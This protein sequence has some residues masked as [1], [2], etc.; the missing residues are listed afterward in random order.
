MR[1]LWVINRVLPLFYKELGR[2]ESN[3]GGGWLTGLSNTIRKTE[4]IEFAVCSY[5]SGIDEIKRGSVEGVQ[6]FFYPQ[7]NIREYSDASKEYI[8][9]I[10]EDFNPDV[11]HVFGTEYPLT[12]ET[13]NAVEPKKV[14]ISLTGILTE[15]AK[16]YR[17]GISR[18]EIGE[19][20]IL[21]FLGSLN[22]RLFF[23]KNRLIKS[24]E[25]DFYRRAKIEQEAIKKAK[26]VTGRTE[27][28]KKFANDYNPNIIYLACNE[29]LRDSFYEGDTW[30]YDSCKKHSIFISNAGYPIKGFHK[31]LDACRN[32]VKKYPD[33]MIYIAGNSPFSNQEGLKN[34][35]IQQTDEYGLYLKKKIDD[36]GLSEH[37]EYL[38]NINEVNMKKQFLQANVFVLP[39]VIENSPNSLGEAMLLGVPCI[40]SDVGGVRD[41]MQDGLEGIIYSFDDTPALEAAISHMFEIQREAGKYGEKAKLKARKTHCRETNNQTMIDIYNTIMNNQKKGV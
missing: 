24:G 33:L 16:V 40:A 34:Y 17:G 10:A 20:H 12:L 8:K 22:A 29:S 11:V 18:A 21:R 39:S 4:E 3:F 2:D 26:Y 23:L 5:L 15:Y 1:I 25:E 28:D 36:Y 31:V 7:S 35:I 37:V 27:F 38:G 41:M 32:I 13:L 9:R 14:L 6:Y 19:H 30:N